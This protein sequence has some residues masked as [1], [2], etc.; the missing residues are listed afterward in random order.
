MKKISTRKFRVIALL[1]KNGR[2]LLPK[3]LPKRKENI[4]LQKHLNMNIY[5][6]FIHYSPK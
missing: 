2:K 6:S 5:S 4:Y 1:H 3:E